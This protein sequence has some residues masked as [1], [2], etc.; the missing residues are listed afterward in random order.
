MKNEEKNEKEKWQM[1]TRTKLVP[2]SILVKTGGGG[3]KRRGGGGEGG[4]KEQKEKE[5]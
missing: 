2:V 4:E 3:R 5:P 1:L